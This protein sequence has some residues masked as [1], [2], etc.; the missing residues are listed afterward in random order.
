MAKAVV[1]ADAAHT[2][3]AIEQMY[4]R[5]WVCVKAPARQRVVRLTQPPCL[6]SCGGSGGSGGRRQNRRKQ[7]DFALKHVAVI[8]KTKQFLWRQT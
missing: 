6:F 8:G 2:A 5:G 3:S 4:R 1:T 7:G